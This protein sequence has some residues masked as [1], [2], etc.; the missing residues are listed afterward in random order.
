MSSV[1]N[2]R[3][4]FILLSASNFKNSTFSYNTSLK[5]ENLEHNASV[6]NTILIFLTCIVSALAT[7]GNLLVIYF[8]FF[9][10]RLQ[11]VSN[12]PL[13]SL[14]VADLIVGLYPINANTLEAV[15]GYWPFTNLFCEF[16]LV[17]DYFCCQSSIY[18]VIIISIDRYLS[19]KQPLKYRG[20]RRKYAVKLSILLLWIVSFF[21]W[22]PT[23]TINKYVFGRSSERLCYKGFLRFDKMSIY[24]FETYILITSVGL[25]YFIVL[26]VVIFIYVK[27][28]FLIKI[29]N[30]IILTARCYGNRL[31]NRI[32]ITV[33][34]TDGSKA[35]ISNDIKLKKK[36]S[37]ESVKSLKTSYP[38]QQKDLIRH[39]KS[40][41]VIVRILLVFVITWFPY[42]LQIALLLYC[43]NC[44]NRLAFDTSN[45]LSYSNSAVNPFVYA[46]VSPEFRSSFYKRIK[47]IFRF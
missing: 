31:H 39:K 34:S 14:S 22:A 2:A 38:L 4:I 9:N 36:R 3:A 19:I 5:T 12:F 27:I 23:I 43:R 33:C 26:P 17:L 41:K 18:H 16:T 45:V 6:Y 47:K 10:K 20:D 21:L 46:F 1:E 40:L 15:L 24:S 37:N 42:S 11:T 7:F 25:G 28:Y 32:L 35:E 30:N 44:F 29:Q 13:L 8:Y